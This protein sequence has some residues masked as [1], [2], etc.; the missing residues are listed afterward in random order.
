MKSQRSFSNLYFEGG[1]KKTSLGGVE[2][3]SIFF[4]QV[5]NFTLSWTLQSDLSLINWDFA[6]ALPKVCMNLWLWAYIC[7]VWTS[8][9]VPSWSMLSRRRRNASTERNEQFQR[10]RI[11]KQF[12]GNIWTEQTAFVYTFNLHTYKSNNVIVH[13]VHT[14]E[15]Q[16]LSNA[17]AQ[18]KFRNYITKKR[19]YIEPIFLPW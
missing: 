7:A 10:S 13:E 5:V 12:R 16:C 9:N 17:Y 6:V 2:N 3:W 15:R 8:R 19:K 11:T 4:E 1:K 18:V 14:T